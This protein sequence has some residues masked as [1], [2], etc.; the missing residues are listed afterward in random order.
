M[1][2]AAPA[3]PHPPYWPLLSHNETTAQASLA[4]ASWDR[5]LDAYARGSGGDGPPPSA[6][7]VDAVRAAPESPEA[8]WALLAAEEAVLGSGTATLSGRGGPGRGG[9]SLF[10]LYQAATKV[11]PRQNN[12]SNAAYIR[13]WLGFAR[14]Q[15]WVKFCCLVGQPLL[16]ACWLQPLHP[17]ATDYTVL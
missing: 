4:R 16:G 2:T 13:L 7:L 9:V 10:D 6:S 5:Q 17:A 12:Y 1:W 14:Q 15:W 8:W 3:S 11:V